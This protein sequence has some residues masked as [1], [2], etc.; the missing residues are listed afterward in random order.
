M[1]VHPVLNRVVPRLA[2]VLLTLAPAAVAGGPDD[3]PEERLPPDTRRVSGFG[4]R[5]EW[6]HDGERILFVGQPMGEVYELNLTTGLTRPLTRHFHH[7]GF[8]R[9]NYLPSGDILLA[10][11]TESFDR[12]DPE[13]R[14]WARHH[15]ALSV[16]PAAG[17]P[18]APLGVLA[19]EGPAV[20]RHRPRI[21]WTI[22]DQ[23]D[24]SLPE[25]TARLYVGDIETRDGRPALVNRRLVFDSRRLPFALGGASLETQDFVPPD[26]A[27][28]IF[29]VY[30][31]DGGTNT[32]TYVVD[33]D[34]GEYR[35]LT[36]SP[37]HYDEPEGVFPRGESVLVEHH[38]SNG[39]AWGLSDL[40][41]LKLDGSGT[42][43]RLTRFTD[44]P[45]FKA[46]QGIVSDDGR[47]LCFQLGKSGDEAGVGYGFFV[48]DL[49]RA[50][51]R[52]GPFE[53][54]ADDAL[55]AQRLADRY[56]AAHA[57]GEP[58]PQFSR[59]PEAAE[60]TLADAYDVQRNWTR[61][62]FGPEDAASGAAA[63]E[64][65]ATGG[66]G[67][68]KGGVVTPGG[69]KWLGVTEPIGALLPAAGLLRAD[70]DAPTVVSLAERPGLSIETEIGFV[71]GRRIDRELTTVEEFLQHMRAVVPA[72]ELPAGRWAKESKPTPADLAAINVSAAEYLVGPEA[73]PRALDLNAV[74]LSLSRDRETLHTA[75][76]SDCWKGPAET[77]LW[78]AQ[79]AWRQGVVLEPGQI[80]LCGALGGPQKAEPGRYVATFGKLGTLGTLGTL[81]F[82][83]TE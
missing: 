80:I 28:L 79:F 61:A 58:L 54:F 26:D 22:R 41:E 70:A 12:A 47:K 33:L 39:S 56:A 14:K 3:F 76:G 1:I 59:Q 13:A 31:I 27:K 57:A 4:E 18:P 77:G 65:A 68:V 71:V 55:P 44:V 66:L 69:Q 82:D 42:M 21:A 37:D 29:S 23:Q 30:R 81:R 32:D 2:A 67:G 48:T 38:P 83:V 11:P 40:Y 64:D 15:C 20:S 43:R 52:F 19:A 51:S 74:P 34:T 45:G 16:L 36:R 49:E 63:P 5:P 73:D 10:G 25:N 6:S 75:V 78:L 50:E 8:T 62:A 46:T 17:G 7:Y 24:P 35:N 53:S 60:M 72:V 9:A